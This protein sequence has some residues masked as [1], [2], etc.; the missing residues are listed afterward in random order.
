M[1]AIFGLGV[2]GILSA[3]EFVTRSDI[4]KDIIK[5]FIER[6]ERTADFIEDFERKSKED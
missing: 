4:V 3:A 5:D 1:K 6:T 2:V